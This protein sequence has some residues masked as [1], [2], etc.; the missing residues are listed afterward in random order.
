MDVRGRLLFFPEYAVPF[1]F[2]RAYIMYASLYPPPPHPTTLTS[3]AHAAHLGDTHET[4]SFCTKDYINVALGGIDLIYKR[5]SYS[6][7]I[8]LLASQRTVGYRILLRRHNFWWSGSAFSHI[9]E[10]VN[11]DFIWGSQSTE[12]N[13][14]V[15]MGVRKRSSPSPS[16][17]LQVQQS[18]SAHPPTSFMLA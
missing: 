9:L 4:L 2:V 13:T 12:L 11:R 7:L 5:N 17:Q 15:G 3:V 18:K 14:L 6:L 1:C 16:L 8:S 10:S